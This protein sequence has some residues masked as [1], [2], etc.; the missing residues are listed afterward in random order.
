MGVAERDVGDGNVRA[1]L[2]SSGGHGERR[3][4]ECGAAD[5][6]ER[7]IAHHETAL[8]SEAITDFSEGALLTGFGALSV[9]DVQGGNV[10]GTLFANGESGTDGGVHAAG[11]SDYGI[12]R[13]KEFSFRFKNKSK[14]K[15]LWVEFAASQVIAEKTSA[16]TWGTRRFG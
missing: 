13:H 7:L 2:R 11:E 14:Y 12:N 3:I 5:L 16:R 10:G 9:G 1:D 4:G 15:G 8:D 6:A